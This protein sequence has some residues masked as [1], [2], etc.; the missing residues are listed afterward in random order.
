MLIGARKIS[1]IVGKR[2]RLGDG[3]IIYWHMGR[4]ERSNWIASKPLVFDANRRDWLA[5]ELAGAPIPVRNCGHMVIGAPAAHPSSVI[6]HR[7]NGRTGVMHS[8]G[9]KRQN[10]YCAKCQKGTHCNDSFVHTATTTETPK[11]PFTGYSTV[12]DFARLRGLSTL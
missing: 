7:S 3:I 1:A 2:M 10:S 6:N 4:L 11:E 9:C 5:H 12:T 8:V